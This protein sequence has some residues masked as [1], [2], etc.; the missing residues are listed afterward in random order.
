MNCKVFCYG[1]FRKS[2]NPLGVT[3]TYRFNPKI[4]TL[5]KQYPKHFGILKMLISNYN[6]SK[7]CWQLLMTTI[8]SVEKG[9][10]V[11]EV[12]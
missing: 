7:F 3:S 12:A 11:C 1:N 8:I 9:S 10:P 6:N 4:L 5:R 2:S